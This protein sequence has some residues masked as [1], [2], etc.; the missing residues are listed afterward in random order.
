MKLNKKNL[1]SLKGTSGLTDD[2]IDYILDEWDSYSGNP[3]AIFTDVLTYGCVSGMVG[4]LIYY[5]D[6]TK[7]YE[8]HK[9]EIN[10]L[11]QECMWECGTH[12]PRDIFGDKW[13]EEDPLALDYTNQNLLAWFGFEE[14]MRKVGYKFE[15]LEDCI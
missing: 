11:L 2:V 7:Y 8:E 15:D 4:H 13:D 3:K 9:T 10:E 1:K 14:T 6:T 5:A 12:N